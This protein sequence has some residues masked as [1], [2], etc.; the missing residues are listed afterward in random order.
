[1]DILKMMLIIF[2]INIVY[3]SLFTMRIIL[4]MKSQQLLAAAL[5]VVE[6]LVYLIGLNLVLNSIDDP[7]NLFA[8]CIGYG[9]GVLLGGKIEQWLALG[10]ITLQ[11]VVDQGESKL[12]IILRDK[13]Y[14]VTSWTAE[15]KD[16]LRLVMQVLAKRSNENKLY[17]QIHEISPRAFI[18]SY[19]P[20]F[21]RGGFWTKRINK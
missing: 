1:M 20:R 12:P 11:I 16:G 2:V 7:F 14:G 17:K 5:S 13:G 8:Y 21:F 4:V 6:V 9:T 10:Y 3:V 19:E 18:I 15:G